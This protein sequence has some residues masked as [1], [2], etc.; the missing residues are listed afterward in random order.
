[1]TGEQ[2]VFPVYIGDD[3]TDEDAFRALKNEGLT[4]YIGE[5]GNSCAQYYLKSTDEVSVFLRRLLESKKG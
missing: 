3:V 4:I 2:G 5:A 1:M